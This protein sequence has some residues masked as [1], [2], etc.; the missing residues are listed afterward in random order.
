MLQSLENP[1]KIGSGTHLLVVLEP[2]LSPP[3]S[4]LIFCFLQ[5]RIEKS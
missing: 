3:L 4:A 2:N 5:F 1:L